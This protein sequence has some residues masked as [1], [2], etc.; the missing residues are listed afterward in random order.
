MNKIVE[1]I[2]INSLPELE[3]NK[4]ADSLGEEVG[5]VLNKALLEC[6]EILKKYGYSVSVT[7]NFH[8]LK[9]LDI[10]Q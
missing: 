9:D 1:R 10:K 7:L 4:M 2:D 3:K 6:N 8:E 5:K